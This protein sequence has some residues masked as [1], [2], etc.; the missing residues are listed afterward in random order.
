MQQHSDTH[1]QPVILFTNTHPVIMK[2]TLKYEC[3][4]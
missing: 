2:T 3:N 4:I 1:N